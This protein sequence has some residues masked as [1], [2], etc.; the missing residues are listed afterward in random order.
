MTQTDIHSK[1]AYLILALLLLPFTSACPADKS[2]DPGEYAVQM[3][4]SEMIRHPNRYNG[5]D[6][7]TGVMMKALEGIWRQ[8]GDDRYYQYIIQTVD[9]VIAED[10]TIAGYDMEAFNID[11]INEGRTLLFLYQQTKD[12]KYKKA[13]ISANT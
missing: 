5:W 1:S 6:Y 13:A 9:P 2:P 4:E 11:Q 10:G 7:V 8:T 3:V 12:E